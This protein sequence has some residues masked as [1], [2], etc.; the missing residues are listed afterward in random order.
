MPALTKHQVNVLIGFL[1]AWYKATHRKLPPGLAPYSGE[2]GPVKRKMI[3]VY[4]KAIG[5]DPTGLLDAKTRKMLTPVDPRAL[6]VAR[7]MSYIHWGVTNRREFDY[8]EQRPISDP[9]PEFLYELPRKRDCSAFSFDALHVGGFAPVTEF[10]FH[11][12]FGNTDSILAWAEKHDRFRSIEVL[13]QADLIVYSRPGH[14]VVVT[15]PHHANPGGAI[16]AASDGH[17][18]APVYVTHDEELRSHPGPCHGVAV[19]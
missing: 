18:G 15:S 14:V 8:D 3:L 5:I 4:Q 9:V 2:V 1:I 19:D 6:H 16:W 12:G 13:R 17:Q 7:T 11:S 10:A